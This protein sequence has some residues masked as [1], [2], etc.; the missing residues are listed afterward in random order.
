MIVFIIYI[1]FV[2]A[3]Y[4]SGILLS[5]SGIGIIV[6]LTNIIPLKLG[7]VANDGYNIISLKRIK[8]LDMLL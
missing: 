7:G 5:F 4:L 6:G 1:I 3:A 8:M 2:Q